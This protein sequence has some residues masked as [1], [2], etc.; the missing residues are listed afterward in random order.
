MIK[1][2]EIDF[3]D[4]ALYFEAKSPADFINREHSEYNQRSVSLFCL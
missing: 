3:H 2:L 4:I 1:W